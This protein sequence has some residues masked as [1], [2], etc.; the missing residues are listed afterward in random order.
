MKWSDLSEKVQKNVEEIITDGLL[1]RGIRANV[2]CWEAKDGKLK[3]VTDKF[4]TTPVIFKELYIEGTGYFSQT[5]NGM[6]ELEVSLAYR[7]Q[8]FSGG[9]NGT[10]LCCIY[11]L[12][13][14]YDARKRYTTT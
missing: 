11:I 10:S 9:F 5:E 8:S 12:L 6:D 4:Y 13:S 14:G 7:W 1:A 3:V 2:T